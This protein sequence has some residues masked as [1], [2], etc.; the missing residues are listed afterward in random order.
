MLKFKKVFN[1]KII[2]IPI[3]MLFVFNSAVY[4]IDLP[5]NTLHN[6]L[7][8]P[9]GN[10][11]ERM[12]QAMQQKYE[13][14]ETSLDKKI[15]ELAKDSK[16]LS[17]ISGLENEFIAIIKDGG[18]E[19]MLEKLNIVL[20]NTGGRIQVIFVEDETKLPQFEGKSVWGHAG[21]FITVFAVREKGENEEAVENDE[22]IR[23]R[24]I[25]RIFH[26]IRARSTIA[27][28]RFDEVNWAAL[29]ESEAEAKIR[30]LLS[31]FEKQNEEIQK[32]I[33]A[34]RKISSGTLFSEFKALEFDEQVSN[35]LRDYAMTRRDF[36][37][38][39]ALALGAYILY[40]TRLLGLI[41]YSASY[42]KDIPEELIDYVIVGIDEIPNDNIEGY[43]KERLWTKPE[44]IRALTD[45]SYHFSV[46]R[47]LT[48]SVLSTEIF[49]MDSGVR[50]DQESVI[51]TLHGYDTFSEGIAQLQVRHAVR[52]FPALYEDAMTPGAPSYL[53]EAIEP[54]AYLSTSIGERDEKGALIYFKEIK[55]ILKNDVLCIYMMTMYI[56]EAMVILHESDPLFRDPNAL[57]V[58]SIPTAFEA[59][60]IGSYYVY[61]P[62]FALNPDNTSVWNRIVGR[63]VSV[64]DHNIYKI[65]VHQNGW[66]WLELDKYL[67]QDGINGISMESTGHR[68][69]SEVMNWMADVW[70]IEHATPY[71]E[72]LFGLVL[73]NKEDI[74]AQQIPPQ[75]AYMARMFAHS[76]VY[77]FDVPYSYPNNWQ[78]S[79]APAIPTLQSTPPPVFVGDLPEGFGSDTQGI[80]YTIQQGNAQWSDSLWNV[81]T[82]VFNEL[83]YLYPDA[84]DINYILD[85]II[86]PLNP[87]I[88]N[89]DAIIYPG[90]KIYVY[91]LAQSS[92]NYIHRHGMMSLKYTDPTAGLRKTRNQI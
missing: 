20:G 27:K 48:V 75:Y 63:D 33:E 50:R 70:A 59:S 9:V 85:S 84:P 17:E 83:N 71:D 21:T 5:R 38:L 53:K 37:K 30:E 45:A 44:N 15:K 19:N 58:F 25:G 10:S 3:I 41:G 56:R 23:K 24:I 51:S 92:V 6:K 77:G 42:P 69:F 16:S 62:P 49:A 73:T 18:F 28:K 66:N 61:G 12:L 39:G 32:Q 22:N 64:P 82:R 81:A 90:Q 29:S 34:E 88:A 89:R 8:V 60:A 2:S 52:F 4:G 36:L 55:D 76:P 26:E 40:R 74:L 91:S 11:Y 87:N 78:T 46:S 47:V 72:G 31:S 54:Y 57:D 86:I 43:V 13:E 79:Q 35:R 80:F 1:I 68:T 67:K 65:K 14:H 7:R